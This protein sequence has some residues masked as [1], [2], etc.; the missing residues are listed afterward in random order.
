MLLALS[1]TS[2]RFLSGASAIEAGSATSLSAPRVTPGRASTVGVPSVPSGWT[3][4]FNRSADCAAHKKFARPAASLVNSRPLKDTSWLPT[5]GFTTWRTLWPS[6]SVT[7]KKPWKFSQDSDTAVLPSGFNAVA[8]VRPACSMTV[9]T[10]VTNWLVLVNAPC[11][12]ARPTSRWSSG[13]FEPLTEPLPEPLLEPSAVLLPSSAAAAAAA[14]TS[15]RVFLR[16][17]MTGLPDEG[18]RTMPGRT[19]QQAQ[20]R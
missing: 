18:N 7:V 10:G 4:N 19:G 3:G 8:W 2:R 12:P 14:P 13:V 5:T 17:A 11:G 15:G 9:P 6:R 16:D 1:V 20:P